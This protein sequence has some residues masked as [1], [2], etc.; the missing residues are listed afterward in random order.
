MFRKLIVTLAAPLLLVAACADEADRAAVEVRTGAEAASAL[1]SAPDA[2]TESGT[3]AFEM[4][5]DMTVDGQSFDILATG[6][7]DAAAQRMSMEMDMGAMFQRLAAADD[8][9]VPAGFDEPWQVVADG[10]T[11]Y[12]RA[13]MFRMLTGADGWLS[14]TPDALGPG[15]EGLGLGAG[16]Y[17]FTELLDTLRGVV[18]EPEVVGQETV[19]GVE[20]TRYSITMDLATAIERAP[21]DQRER[22]EAQLDRLGV[23]AD[24]GVPVEV[25]LDADDLPRR[26]RMDMGSMLAGT[27]LGDG[28]TAAM[29]LEVFDYGEPVTI[30]VPSADEVT[31][32]T[33]L[34]GGLLGARSRASRS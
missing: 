6:A 17:D 16:S 24:A 19:R 9:E 27:D 8:E 25:W 13:A 21:A 15:A 30:D 10:T 4:V 1:R 32:F 3:A 14:V 7:L 11:V 29:T 12:L 18:G 22:L 33:D 23:S 5:M 2:V 31:P 26:L 28:A 34:M 20:T